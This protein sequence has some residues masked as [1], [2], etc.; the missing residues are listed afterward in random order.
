MIP[1]W[2]IAIGGALGAVARYITVMGVDAWMG[3]DFPYATLS[4]NVLGS[5]LA[6]F[7]LMILDH[8]WSVGP[9]IRGF[10]MIGF[11][12]G[13]TTFSAFSLDNLNLLLDGQ[14][15]KAL[16]NALVSVSVCLL[17]AWLGVVAA[18]AF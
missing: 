13:F 18:R 1:L 15:T 14:M 3:R 11:L 7:C 12:G 8:R 9:E 10:I 4:V 16:I 6:G 2:I 5:F 17:A